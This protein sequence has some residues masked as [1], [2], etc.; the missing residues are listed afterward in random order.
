MHHILYYK[1]KGS[2]QQQL[3]QKGRGILLEVGIDH[4]T[5]VLNLVYAPK[6]GGQH[7]YGNLKALVDALS[8]ARGDYGKV[9]AVLIEYGARLSSQMQQVN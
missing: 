2:L 1:G 6:G 5:S 9:V 7:T 4:K 3:V 8:E